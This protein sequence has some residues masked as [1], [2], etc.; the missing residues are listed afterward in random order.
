[1][2]TLELNS[3]LL[4]FW[5]RNLHFADRIAISA[6]GAETTFMHTRGESHLNSVL[7]FFWLRNLHF[8]DRIAISAVGAE[9]TFMHTRG[10]SHLRD[11]N[12]RGA[13]A[14]LALN[15]QG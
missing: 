15:D 11:L 12:T 6:V 13:K 8:A 3:V 14:T 2:L 4:F 9:T 5:L 7:L 10:E 1:M